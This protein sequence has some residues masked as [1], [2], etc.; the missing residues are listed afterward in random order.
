MKLSSVEAVIRALLAAD[1]RFLIAGGLAVKVYGF[2]LLDL[3][4]L[5]GLL[6]DG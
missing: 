5:R 3:E 6:E 4:R 1:A 2:R